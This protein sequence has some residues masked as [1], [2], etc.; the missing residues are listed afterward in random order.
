MSLVS[1]VNLSVEGITT[2]DNITNIG[3]YETI[4]EGIL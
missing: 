4:Y 3:V 1:T 2:A